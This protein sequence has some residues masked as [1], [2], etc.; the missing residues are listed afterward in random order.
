MNIPREHIQ[1]FQ[2]F[3][4]TERE[5]R[6]LCIVAVHSGY[7]TQRQYTEFGPRKAGCIASGF[8]NKLL[9]RGH[10]SEHKYQ[11]NT[12]VLHFTFKPMYCAIGKENI[13]N[14]RAHSFEFMKTRLA[15]LDFVLRH[16]QH[17]YLEG[18]AEKVQYF[19]ERFQIRPQDMPGRTY[20]GANKVPDTIR[21]FVDK[22]P[23]FLDSTLQNEPRVTLTFIDPGSRNL[24]AFKTHLD[25]YSS[26]L[27][28][29][30]RFAFLFA[31][32]DAGPFTAAE[33]LFKEVADPQPGNL[34]QQVAR[35]FKLRAAFEAKRFELLKDPDIEFMNHAKQC[36]AGDIFE[37]S[38]AEWKAGRLTQ[39]DLIAV[40]ENRPRR[41]QEIE[42]KTYLLPHDYSS[43]GQNSHFT[44]KTA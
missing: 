21:Y 16:T 12:R 38:F 34:S 28:R 13:R 41:K 29:V 30:G 3:G 4:Y 9:A 18:E 20:R 36:F 31:S 7:F 1:A 43:F 42:F 33:K 10:A 25:A 2:N 14:R 27:G 24:E 37:R 19:E 40:L 44:Q 5:A 11:N 32:P 22:F 15:I 35:Y 23:L 26:F 6:F 8:T 17:D 39:R